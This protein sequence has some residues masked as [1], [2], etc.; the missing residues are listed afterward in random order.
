MTS[1]KTKFLL[2]ILLV[3]LILKINNSSSKMGYFNY[4]EFIEAAENDSK[5]IK[6]YE[7]K[8]K[9]LEYEKNYLEIEKDSLTKHNSYSK[10]LEALY[11][12]EDQSLKIK[13]VEILNRT[14]KEEDKLKLIEYD[15]VFSINY[16]QLDSLKVIDG[17]LNKFNNLELVA[18]SHEKNTNNEFLNDLELIVRVYEF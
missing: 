13:G 11:G 9:L 8:K 1:R 18:Y 10:I 2:L 16:N 17:L 15:L 12:L 6:D 4:K 5:L 7:N 3:V 14:G